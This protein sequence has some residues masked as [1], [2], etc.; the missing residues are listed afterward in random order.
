MWKVRV[1]NMA[2]MEKNSRIREKGGETRARRKNQEVRAFEI[3][4]DAN[5]ISNLKL[6]CL[7]RVFVEGK[8][9]MNYIIAKGI[10]ETVS[11]KD[12]SIKKVNIKVKDKFEER[13]LN[14]LSSQMKEYIIKRLQSNVKTLTKLKKEG[15]KIGKIKYRRSLHSIPLMQYGITYKIDIERKKVHI[16]SL[17]DFKVLG[18]SQIP[19][20]SEFATANLI[21]RNGNYF[22]HII[23]YAPKKEKVQNSKSIGIDLGIKNQI[24]FS[25]GVQVRYNVPMAERTKRLYRAFSRSKYDKIAR[26]R[27]KRGMKLLN[28]I[29]MEFEHQNNH[30]KDINNKLAHYVTY[31]YQYISYQDD[32]ISS[33][34]KFYGRKIYQTSIGEFRNAIKRK[35]CTPLKVGRFAR[36]TGIC[37]NCGESQHL[38]LSD[39]VFACPSC[40][41][42]SDRDV[43]AAKTINKLGLSLWNIG[44]TLA[45]DY[46]YTTNMLEYIKCIPHVKAS[47]SV[48][49]RSPKLTDVAEAPSVRAG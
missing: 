49:A 6:N 32:S 42:T 13:E 21:D 12:Y 5:K 31:N 23:A 14:V 24:T 18:L 17:G 43:S 30:K 7:K 10:T 39:R 27:S 16:Q 45:E 41:Y 40:G 19:E 44:E 29:K 28:R 48:E 35:A 33:W 4:F 38:D 15:K 46:A 25:N 37:P 3:K 47:I 20:D 2:N 22:L 26:T 1:N 9:F 8:W 11:H 36:T 34:S